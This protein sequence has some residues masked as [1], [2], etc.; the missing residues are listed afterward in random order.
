M[1]EEILPQPLE[2]FEEADRRYAALNRQYDSGNLSPD[3]FE[4]PLKEIIVYLLTA[5]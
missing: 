1:Q 2:A 3:G 4:T 5:R